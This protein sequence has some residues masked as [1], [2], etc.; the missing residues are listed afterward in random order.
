MAKDLF[1]KQNQFSIRKLTVGVCSVIIGMSFLTPQEA[2]ANELTTEP[3]N[4]GLTPLADSEALGETSSED[5][6]DDQ[7]SVAE[8][9]AEL[10]E[11]SLAEAPAELQASP[12]I[13]TRAAGE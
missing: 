11:A 8:T 4:T 9:S 1:S 12:A 2:A 7:A 10:A 5:L 13:A 3:T 6:V